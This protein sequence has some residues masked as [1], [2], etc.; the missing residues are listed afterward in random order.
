VRN[1]EIHR[2]YVFKAPPEDDF[3]LKRLLHFLDQTAT[4]N[5]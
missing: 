4:L 1:S 5:S 2:L 3:T